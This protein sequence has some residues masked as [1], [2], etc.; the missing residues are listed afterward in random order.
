M[1]QYRSYRLI[2]LEE[3]QGFES[4]ADLILQ[5]PVH[6]L[7]LVVALLADFFLNQAFNALIVV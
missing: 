1:G 5:C 2:L 7:Q 4:D 6:L 3:D